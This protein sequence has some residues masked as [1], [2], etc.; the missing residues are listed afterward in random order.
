MA[1]PIFM[2]CP[3]GAVEMLT[4]PPRP[5]RSRHCRTGS[6]PLR[7]LRA[8]AWY[9][10][11]MTASMTVRDVPVPPYYVGALG[12]GLG[13]LLGALGAAA[14]AS[15]LPSGTPHRTTVTTAAILGGTALGVMAFTP[16]P[17]WTGALV[18]SAAGI[19]AVYAAG[20]APGPNAW[21]VRLP[22]LAGALPAGAFA[23]AAIAGRP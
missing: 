11:H 23:G 18:G 10:G 20:S 16:R 9:R 22:V 6:R 2:T 14:S 5:N 4:L 15:L 13:A 17:Q 12:A 19:A 8:L 21:W 7:P 1:S 3:C